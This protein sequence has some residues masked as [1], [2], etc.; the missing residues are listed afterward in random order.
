[1][2]DVV[3]H[4]SG[5]L[6][7]LLGPRVRFQQ[8]EQHHENVAEAHGHG[9]GE[10]V[11]ALRPLLLEDLEEDNIEETSSGQALEHEQCRP[12]ILLRIDC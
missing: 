7:P 6:L 11:D 10:P 4:H 3:D 5:P 12:S 1:M 8:A 2:E 9:L